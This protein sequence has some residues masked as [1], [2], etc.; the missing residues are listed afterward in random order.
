[1]QSKKINY[2][3]RKLN[4]VSKRASQSIDHGSTLF[5]SQEFEVMNLQST[6]N[7]STFKRHFLNE[8]ISK[9]NDSIISG[10][11]H[12]VQSGRKTVIS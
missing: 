7:K 8:P 6:L 10:K 3:K 9:N 12:V 2:K 5:D 11:G 4:I 1:M